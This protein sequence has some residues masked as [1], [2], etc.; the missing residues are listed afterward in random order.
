MIILKVYTI[1]ITH[2]SYITRLSQ[3]KKKA[4]TVRNRASEY[5]LHWCVHYMT[6]ILSFACTLSLYIYYNQQHKVYQLPK[7]MGEIIQFENF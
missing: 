5:Q 6:K 1:Q 4:H 3:K 7:N 2:Q